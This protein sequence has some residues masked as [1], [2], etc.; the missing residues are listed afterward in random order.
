MSSL[1]P[2]ANSWPSVAGIGTGGRSSVPPE[3][4]VAPRIETTDGEAP[5]DTH[6][7]YLVGTPA[8]RSI[9][10]PACPKRTRRRISLRRDNK[11]IGD[12][13]FQRNRQLLKNCHRWVFEPPL[14]T[15]DIGSVDPRVDGERLLRKSLANAQSPDIPGHQS[16]RFHARKR[17]F[18]G[19]LNHGQ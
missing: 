1:R 12:G 4:S 5:L 6:A 11:E 8:A 17:P 19:L 9:R 15:T 13:R 3:M 10:P 16:L 18:I 2:S 14:K 7:P